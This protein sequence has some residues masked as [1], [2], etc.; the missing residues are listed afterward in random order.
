MENRVVEIDQVLAVACNIGARLAIDLAIHYLG[1]H[2]G[3]VLI[4]DEPI[5][6][7]QYALQVNMKQ[8]VLRNNMLCS[9]MKVVIVVT[10]KSLFYNDYM[11]NLTWKAMKK[12]AKF[13]AVDLNKSH[14]FVLLK[15]LNSA[16]DNLQQ[17]IN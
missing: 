2:I 7:K 14:V 4:Y 9:S 13:F 10:M 12:H 1:F 17:L 8:N 3:V 5:L 6:F 11:C 15:L 16:V